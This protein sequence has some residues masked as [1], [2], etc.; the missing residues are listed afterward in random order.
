VA[1]WNLGDAGMQA[2]GGQLTATSLLTSV[3]ASAT[4]NAVGNWVQIY[5]AV[6]FPVFGMLVHLGQTGIATSAQ[7]SQTLLDVGV[8]ASGQ[9]QVLV[10]DVAIG[11]SLP[12]T[13][14]QIPM[15]VSAGARIAVRL[16][17]AVASKTCTIG[18]SVYGGGSGLESG[19]KAVTYGAVTASSRGTILTAPGVINTEAAWTVITTATTA[20]AGWLLVGLAAPNS[21]TATANDGLVDIGVGGAGVEAAI[22]NDIP[23]GV[24]VAEDINCPYPLTYPVNLPTG[25]RLVARY[26]ATAIAAAGTPNVTL[27]GIN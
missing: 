27:T 26:R 16:R 6:P 1:N 20:R 22:I 24:T 2:M 9:E 5:T 17:S 19:Y 23:Y 10:S 7:N 3:A 21:A 25:S 13:T 4:V 15:S 8:G 12:F 14:W 11:G 18:I